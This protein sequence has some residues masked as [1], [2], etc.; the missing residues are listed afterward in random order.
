MGRPALPIEPYIAKLEQALL[1]GATYE[2]AALYAG[3]SKRTLERWRQRAK[4]A[5][6][7]T[8]LALL[9]QRLSQAEG[10][11]A[12]SWL[13]QIEQAAREGDW[14]AAAFKLQSRYPEA[15]GNRARVD[16]TLQIQKAAQEVADEIGIDV[17]LVLKEAQSY[18]QEERHGGH[19]R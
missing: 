1:L 14:R 8:P 11:A 5:R 3:I 19:A 6:D 10:R 2:V 4:A 18:L 9:R 12:I 13:A 16:L 15:Y 7:G 17:A